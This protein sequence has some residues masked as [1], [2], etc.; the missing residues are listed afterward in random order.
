MR[1]C[2]ASNKACTDKSRKHP[3]SKPT[4]HMYPHGVAD[5]SKLI[6]LVERASR[7]M[8]AVVQTDQS[9]LG[10][11]VSWSKRSTIGTVF[12]LGSPILSMVAERSDSPL[13]ASMVVDPLSTSDKRLATSDEPA[14]IQGAGAL[15]TRSGNGYYGTC[16]TRA[17][18]RTAAAA[19]GEQIIAAQT[20]TNEQRFPMGHTLDHAKMDPELEHILMDALNAFDRPLYAYARDSGAGEALATAVT[21]DSAVAASSK[22]AACSEH[23]RVTQMNEQPGQ[24]G[25]L[26]QLGTDDSETDA[27]AALHSSQIEPRTPAEA[28]AAGEIEIKLRTPS[29]NQSRGC[30]STTRAA[31]MSDSA[32][33][34]YPSRGC[35][36]KCVAQMS[37]SAPT[38]YL[39]RGQAAQMAD[40]EIEEAASEIN[41][42]TADSIQI[43]DI[44]R[45]WYQ[46]VNSKS[47]STATKLSTS[48]TARHHICADENA[49]FDGGGRY[50]AIRHLC[51][52]SA[53]LS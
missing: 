31:Q 47:K 2:R 51:P 43:R 19:A 15:P 32:H 1:H 20:T 45:V 41:S 4:T 3:A 34:S 49:I 30:T 17:I 22:Q 35:T 18:V 21:D 6:W 11:V 44:I 24:P 33:Y 29:S 36:L 38:R 37:D 5:L 12:N 9:G 25:G 13:R 52:K 27:S 28:E 42:Q 53:S 10:E 46:E 39:S 48:I 14:G 16:N 23:M 50:D 40:F 8:A 7:T 26:A